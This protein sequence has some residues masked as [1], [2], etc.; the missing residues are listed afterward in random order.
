M[1]IVNKTLNEK[2]MN[3]IYG[4]NTFKMDFA[5]IEALK[6]AYPAL[7]IEN[8]LYLYHNK[9]IND[10]SFEKIQ[11]IKQLGIGCYTCEIFSKNIDIDFNLL[12]TLQNY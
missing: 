6:K 1:G 10:I 5:L 8:I 2:M 9:T 3:D 11:K 12:E 7:S 4:F